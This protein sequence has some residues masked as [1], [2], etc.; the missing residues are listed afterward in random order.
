MWDGPNLD[1]MDDPIDSMDEKMG[2][3]DTWGYSLPV[4]PRSQ[5]KLIAQKQKRG[6]AF[7][8]PRFYELRKDTSWSPGT[9]QRH[10]YQWCRVIHR[11]RPWPHKLHEE[12]R[13]YLRS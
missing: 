9:H 10:K 3:R 5:I 13:R 7:A 11:V 8:E 2:S 6:S 1:V 12:Q 4:S